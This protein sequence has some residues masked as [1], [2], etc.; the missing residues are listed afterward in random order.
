MSKSNGYIQTYSTEQPA[1]A[2]LTHNSLYDNFS[3]S[4]K[5]IK[6]IFMIGTPASTPPT[7]MTDMNNVLDEK[8]SDYNVIVLRNRTETYTAKLFSEKGTDTMDIKDIKRY[9]DQKLR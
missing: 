4:Q 5:C 7:F 1:T 6:P 2:I 3:L 9:I 8:L